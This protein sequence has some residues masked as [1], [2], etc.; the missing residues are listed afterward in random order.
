M[1]RIAP[2]NWLMRAIAALVLVFSPAFG[3]AAFDNFESGHVRPLALA[4]DGT[5][6]YAVN[7]PDNRLD[8]FDVDG[9]G[10]TRVASVMVGLEPVAVAA[11]TNGGGQT[12]VWVANHLSDSVSIVLID[13]VVPANSRVVRTLLVGDEPRD[14]VFAGSSGNRAFVT[15]A[16]RGQNSSVAHASQTPGTPRALVWAFDANATGAALGGTPLSVIPLFSDAPR[17]LAVSANGA[18]VYAAAFQSGSRTTTVFEDL[19]QNGQGLPPFPPG[20]TPGAPSTSLI[21]KWNPANSRWED[22]IGRNW[23][24][25]IPFTLPDRDVF[26]INADANPPAPAGGTNFVTGV[27]TTLFN[28]A[29]RPDN[30]KLYVSNL[31]AR[32]HVRFEPLISATQGLRGH[33]AE[34]QITV[35][36]G[37]TPTPHHLNPHIDYTVATGPLSEIVQSAAFPLGMVFSSDGQTLYVAA[38]GSRK[39]AVLDSDD[40]EAGT[41]SSAAI[42]NVGGGPSGLALDEG[43]D[44]LYVMNRF[45]QQIAIVSN[46]SDPLTRKVWKR[47]S[48]SFDPSP[49]AVRS[50]RQFLYDARA[51]S[52]HGDAACATCHLFGDIDKL[53]W[54]LGDPFGA[55]TPDPNPFFLGTPLPFHPAKGPMTTQSLRGM[56][57]TGPLHWRG[58]RTAASD[59]G[60]N[61]FDTAGNFKKFNVAF[62]GLLGRAAPLSAAEL[63]AFTNFV[64]TL[65]YPPNPIRALTNTLT[66]AESTGQ[67]IYLNNLTDGNTFRCNDCHALPLGTAGLSLAVPPQAGDQSLKIPHLRNL[68][69]KVGAYGGAGDQVS[70]FGL[71]HDGSLYSIFNLL[72]INGFVF[73]NDTARRNVESFLLALDTGLRPMVG[74]QVSATPATWNDSTVVARIQLMIDRDVA[75]DCELVVKGVV[76][77]EARGWL[78]AGSD[79][80]QP[81]RAGEPALNKN[82]LRGFAASAGQELTYTCAPPAAGNRMGLDRDQDGRFDRDE[83]DAGFD[84]GNPFDP[85][86]CEDGLDNDGDGLSDLADPGCKD[87]SW[88]VEDPGCND[89][90]DNDHDA[91]TDMADADCGAP[92]SDNEIAVGAGCGLLG[93]EVLPVLAFAAARRRRR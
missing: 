83:L 4:P 41:I 42:E 72:S 11:R 9:G 74:Q 66:S 78:F 51:T 16:R 19:V 30:G 23:T 7:T 75:G 81:D 64:L 76:D 45:D 92:W 58:D 34:S 5:Q 28:M 29:V 39:V 88:Q 49:A 79:L 77:G 89:G 67:N 53:A 15:T 90:I 26:L 46:V 20:T 62:K 14:I 56:L 87:A 18:T 43:N 25:A 85:A 33:L 22:E 6:L 57:G 71:L 55:V 47:V 48:L 91:A 31:L 86:L 60:G 52:G 32:N 17:A 68:Y 63:E 84:P 80:F 44:R 10:L 93:V 3:A 12:E 35:I 82:T 73:A 38:F 37:T 65:E 50:G 59:P 40:L 24:S 8:I 70:G 13:D 36:S 1:S 21:V 27:G 61:A 2:A 54:D 69:Q